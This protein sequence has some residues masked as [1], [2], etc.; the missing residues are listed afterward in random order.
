MNEGTS[1]SRLNIICGG[2]ICL[3]L[4]IFG[5]GFWA[6]RSNGRLENV[7]EYEARLAAITSINTELQNENKRLVE[8]NGTISQRLKDITGRIERAKDIIDGIGNQL[9]QDD[10]TIQRILDNLSK[11]EKAIRIIFEPA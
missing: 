4:F 8:L 10:D 5:A 1:K 3:A 2:F 11:L 6:G 9:D 7:T